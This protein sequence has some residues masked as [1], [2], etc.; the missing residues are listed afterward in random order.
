MLSSNNNGFS[1]FHTARGT[2]L[3]S[4]RAIVASLATAIFFISIARILPSLSELGL[5][6]GIQ[7]IIIFSAILSGSDLSRAAMRFISYHEG[8]G[9]NDSANTIY[10]TVFSIGIGLSALISILVYALADPISAILFHNSVYQ[11][12]IQLSALDIFLFS[13]VTYSTSFLYAMQRFRKASIIL[14]VNTVLKFSLAFI[15]FLLDY[16]IE[17]III[18]FIIGDGIA[19]IIFLIE[20]SPKLRNRIS[21]LKEMKPLIRYSA[22]LFGSSILVYLSR[23]IDVFLLLL[24]TNLTI[25]G[26]YSPAVFTAYILL[27]FLTSVDQSLAPLF[28]R[29][30]GRFGVIEVNKLAKSISRYV[31]LVYFPV[32]FALLASV[33]FLLPSLLGERY[34]ESIYP[35]IIV[36]SA[37]IFTAM[38]PI[39]NNV[40]MSSGRT[41]VFLYA[42]AVG[43]ALQVLVSVFAIPLF[44]ASG[45]AV[46]KAIAYVVAF[47]VPA[48]YLKKV[49]GH[50]PYDR[51]MLWKTLIGSLISALTIL[52]INLSYHSIPAIP[53]SYVCGL[54]V[55]LFILRL[56][57]ALTVKD[58]ETINEILSGNAKFFM[59]IFA[60][61]VIRKT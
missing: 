16:G 9:R 33:P 41:Q 52:L 46:A 3:V 35:S 56:T 2:I 20:L 50:L 59:D 23:E 1:P 13:L 57:K 40:L 22:P 21:S 5:L 24:F 6:Q 53:I 38:I 44:G 7:S 25:V 51:T 55:Y 29:I 34:I 60:K 28:S 48:Y 26:T 14:V 49:Y 18:G 15:L 61:I 4:I 10:P 30:Y 42:S 11:G 36:I 31:F 27:L 12:L 37:L 39:F 17:G 8:G 58:I 54:F 43:V 32:S 19:F 45:A 47:V